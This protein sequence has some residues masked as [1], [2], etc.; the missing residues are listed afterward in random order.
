MSFTASSGT[1]EI[2]SKIIEIEDFNIKF[3]PVKNALATSGIQGAKAARE[4]RGTIRLDSEE[5]VKAELKE[6]INDVIKEKLNREVIFL[7]E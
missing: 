5:I 7:A 4:F 1:L 2:N 3:E 6:I